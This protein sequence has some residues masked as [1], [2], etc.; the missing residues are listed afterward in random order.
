MK[1]KN[2]MPTVSYNGETYKLRSR[3]TQVPNLKNMDSTSALIWLNRNTTAR[4]YQK[5]PNP[6]IGMGGI[7][8]IK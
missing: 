4:G 8:T 6:L 5:V 7:I 2:P 1:V 3:K